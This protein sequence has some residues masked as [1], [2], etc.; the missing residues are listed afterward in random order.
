MRLNYIS[1]TAYVLPAGGLHPTF[2]ISSRYRFHYNSF[3]VYLL[4]KRGISWKHCALLVR[5]P[6]QTNP[7]AGSSL[8]DTHHGKC[9]LSSRKRLLLL[10]TGNSPNT[11][12]PTMPHR[13]RKHRPVKQHRRH[14]DST[15]K[16]AERCELE[17]ES[18]LRSQRSAI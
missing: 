7:S 5:S 10:R 12:S 3:R 15:L 8:T 14:L 18:K 13:H 2:I 16:M 9:S 1:N 4:C 17:T 11:T 6:Q